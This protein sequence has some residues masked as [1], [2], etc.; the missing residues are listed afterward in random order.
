MRRP[1]AGQDV[2]P[3]VWFDNVERVTVA[4]IG[5]EPVRYVRNI[6]NYYIAYKL[7]EEPS[8]CN[9]DDKADWN[10]PSLT[11]VAPAAPGAV[12]PVAG[13]R[14]NGSASEGSEP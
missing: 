14:C 1:A 5:Q 8:S 11:T 4:N 10:R 3:D 12:S 2:K 13:T 6:Y 9:R 7:L